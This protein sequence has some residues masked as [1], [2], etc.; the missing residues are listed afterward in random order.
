MPSEEYLA[1]VSDMGT[2][3]TTILDMNDVGGDPRKKGSS[4]PIIRAIK[5]ELLKLSHNG[6]KTKIQEMNESVV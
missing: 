4:Q 3:H 1:R 5:E 2:P 6:R